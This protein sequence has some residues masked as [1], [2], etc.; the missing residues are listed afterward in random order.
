MLKIKL[1]GASIGDFEDYYKIRCEASDIFWM[2]HTS[3]PNYQMIYGVFSE[4]LGTNQ[5]S[6]I[7]DKVIYMAK[8][9]N[10]VTVGFVMLSL[11]S[12]GIEIGISLFQKYQSLGLG[13]KIIAEAL[14]M[15]LSYNHTVYARI[16]DDNTASQKIFIKN[17][18]NRTEE[19]EMKEYP[20]VGNVAF[21]KYI[22]TLG[23]NNNTQ[24]K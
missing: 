9:D 15:S 13:T 5:L 3:P 14:P 19:F 12:S 8:E 22:Y 11:T 21:R 6:K 1:T 7:G 20:T 4:R 17:G 10:N 16:R 2:G 23:A 18:F 24:R